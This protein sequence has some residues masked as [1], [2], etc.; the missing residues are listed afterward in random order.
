MESQTATYPKYT[1]KK[2]D[3]GQQQQEYLPPKK[4]RF[5]KNEKDST[6]AGKG[7]KIIGHNSELTTIVNQNQQFHKDARACYPFKSES[8][9]TM[10]DS[11]QNLS[12]FIKLISLDPVIVKSTGLTTTQYVLLNYS[13]TTVE[14]MDNHVHFFLQAHSWVTKNLRAKGIKDPSTLEYLEEINKVHKLY[15]VILALIPTLKGN[16]IE[17]IFSVMALWKYM[18][19]QALDNLEGLGLMHN[20]PYT[21]KDTFDNILE[22]EMRRLYKLYV[23][24][25]QRSL[26]PQ[27]V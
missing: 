19:N 5:N 2:V 7:I 21:P 18:F 10:M 6:W 9:Y 23:L 17:D 12:F 27:Q 4:V 26:K 8:Y 11:S 16:P 25:M 15:G 14:E 1:L 13:L 3:S 24:E 20:A 22:N